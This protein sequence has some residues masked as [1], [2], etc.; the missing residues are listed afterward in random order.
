M[1]EKYNKI[2]RAYGEYFATAQTVPQNTTADG[3]EGVQTGLVHGA[4][5]G[6]SVTAEVNTALVLSPGKYCKVTLQHGDSATG[7]F[8]E[9]GTV[10]S[11]T[12]SGTQTRAAGTL[13][14]RFIVPPECKDYTKVV[15]ATDDV[16]ATG[17]LDVFPEMI[18]R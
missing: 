5:G 9:L 14:G 18:P 11:V 4:M 1:G 8:A 17:A 13:L 16:E 10:C 15:L 7:Q 3:D 2:Q 12:G 6:V